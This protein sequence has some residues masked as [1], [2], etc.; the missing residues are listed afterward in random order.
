MKM[1]VFYVPDHMD[2]TDARA[3]AVEAIGWALHDAELEAAKVQVFNAGWGVEASELEVSIASKTSD[4]ILKTEY[5]SETGTVY[6]HWLD[7]NGL[8]HAEQEE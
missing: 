7:H 8:Q 6:H 5:N 1:V 2:E 4:G 3:T